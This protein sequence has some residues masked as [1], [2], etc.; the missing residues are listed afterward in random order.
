MGRTRRLQLG[1]LAPL[2]VL[3]KAFQVMPLLPWVSECWCRL[4][5]EVLAKILLIL[6]QFLFSLVPTGGCQEK[7]A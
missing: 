5:W 2:Q 7:G 4:T 3:G 6:Q 1:E